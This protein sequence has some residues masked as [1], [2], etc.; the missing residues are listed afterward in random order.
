[1]QLVDELERVRR[2]AYAGV[3]GAFGPTGSQL[4]VSQRA[5]VLTRDDLRVYA[6]A[7]IDAASA[8]AAA[9]PP[10]HDPAAAEVAAWT[11]ALAQLTAA[12][13]RP[14]REPD[15]TR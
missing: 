10:T 12:R 9:P 7:M 3:F 15:P 11:A 13:A 4:A 1:M 14:P 2:G 8:L 5:G 6:G